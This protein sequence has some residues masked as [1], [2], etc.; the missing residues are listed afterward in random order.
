MFSGC[1]ST[2]HCLGVIYHWAQAHRSTQHSVGRQFVTRLCNECSEAQPL[3]QG[4]ADTFCLWREGFKHRSVLGRPIHC[5]R[6]LNKIWVWQLKCIFFYLIRQLQRWDFSYA[7]VYGWNVPFYCL[8]FCL[9]TESSIPYCENLIDFKINLGWDKHK[10]LSFHCAAQ[11]SLRFCL[12]LPWRSLDSLRHCSNP[13]H[14]EGKG[15]P[16]TE[17]QVLRMFPG[18]LVVLSVQMA[19]PNSFKPPF[20]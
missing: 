5:P 12:T 20:S 3:L 13:T 6:F 2:V 18:D 7:N 19:F 4:N 1:F 11:G 15:A 17:S 10:Y 9:Q 14:I 8:Q 16:V